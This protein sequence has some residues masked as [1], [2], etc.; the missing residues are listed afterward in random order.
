M[1]AWIRRLNVLGPK[2]HRLGPLE[3]RVLDVLWSRSREAS[4]RD[5]HPSFPD[6]AYTTLMT[7]LDRLYRKGA[8]DRTKRGRAFFYEPRLSRVEFDSARAADALRAALENDQ[9]ALGPLLSCLVDAV[10]DRDTELLE[11]L[12]TLVRERRAQ[13]E[14]RRS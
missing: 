10:G 6:I 9:A 12:E 14:E 4:V 3:Q 2:P 5:L 11:E 1:S 13:L 7:T 8:L